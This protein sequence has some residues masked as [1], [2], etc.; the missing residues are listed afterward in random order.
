MNMNTSGFHLFSF[1]AKQ[2][3]LTS[4]RFQW[5][6]LR[7]T[8]LNISKLNIFSWDFHPKTKIHGTY[9]QVKVS[10]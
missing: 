2:G 3:E 7:N 6:K 9:K 8:E 5:S 1:P 4:L 10:V